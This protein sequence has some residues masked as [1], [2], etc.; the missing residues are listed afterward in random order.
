MKSKTKKVFITLLMGLITLASYSQS[1][2]VKVEYYQEK[3]NKAHKMDE[4]ICD[5]L[6]RRGKKR[7]GFV[8]I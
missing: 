6:I 7:T 3:I 4:A 1:D 2:S 8:E 5:I